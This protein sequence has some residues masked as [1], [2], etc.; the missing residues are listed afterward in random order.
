MK[1]IGGGPLGFDDSTGI[2]G[3]SGTATDAFSPVPESVLGVVDVA[4][5]AAAAFVVDDGCEPDALLVVGVGALAPKP[6][7]PSN[8]K[9]SVAA[10]LVVMAPNG[11]TWATGTCNAIGFSFTALAGK[12][13]A[14]EVG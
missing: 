4:I 2:G 8:A 6:P 3:G 10:E 5:T 14:V 1:L 13:A 11:F 9:S 12:E 7:D